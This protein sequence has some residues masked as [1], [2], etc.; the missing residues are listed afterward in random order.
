MAPGHDTSIAGGR[1]WA[2]AAAMHMR[3][4]ATRGTTV[5]NMPMAIVRSPRN[6]GFALP[7]IL[8]LSLVLLTMLLAAIAAMTTIRQ[9]L[10]SA[11]YDRAAK[12]AAEAG[13][14]YAASCMTKNGFVSTWTDASPLVPG[15]D[16]NGGAQCAPNPDCAVVRTPQY[17]ST[18]SVGAPV[19][20]GTGSQFITARGEVSLQ[21]SSSAT[22]SWKTYTYNLQARIG[23]SILV[24]N[25]AF[26]YSSAGTNFFTLGRDGNV[27]AVGANGAGQL[28]TGSTANA[29]LPTIVNMPS[30]AQ[31]SMTNPNPITT[32][33]LNSGFAAGIAASNGNAYFSGPNNYYQQGMTGSSPNTFVA[34]PLPGLSNE[35]K[36]LGP[37]VAAIPVFYNNYVITANGYVFA[38]GNCEQ[39]QTGTYMIGD[40][41][42]VA[43][44]R[45]ITALPAPRSGDPS[46]LPKTITGDDQVR[47]ILMKDG[48][49]YGWGRDNDSPGW[50]TGSIGIGNGINNGVSYPRPIMLEGQLNCT[51]TGSSLCPMGAR[52]KECK[53][54]DLSTIHCVVNVEETGRATYLLANDGTVWSAGSDWGRGLLGLGSKDARTS[55]FKQITQFPNDGYSHKVVSIHAD[56]FSLSMLTE[57][58]G[59]PWMSAVYTVGYNA[60]GLAGCGVPSGVGG[61]EIGCPEIATRPV[62]F[63]LPSGVYPIYMYNTSNVTTVGG[64]FIAQTDNLYVIGSDKKAYAAGDDTFGQLGDQ[65]VLQGP[66]PYSSCQYASNGQ[67]ANQVGTPVVMSILDGSDKSRTALSI[68]AG[69]GTAVIKAESGIV[70]AV[71]LNDGGQLGDGTTNNSSVPRPNKY[72]NATATLYY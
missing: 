49:V 70:Y 29:L 24:N 30:G 11:Q 61:D 62:R 57:E 13:I 65:C 37:V 35:G 51:T 48:S 18:F 4:F 9:A 67:P 39:G 63:K 36:P 3:R 7:T 15:R 5:Y 26:G 44:P 6:R 55:T 43:T 27:R 2:Q 33:F 54:G 72:L 47:H 41:C 38:S 46:T 23:G 34:Y 20:N 52:Q 32:N 19:G 17:H 1:G 66:A 42:K 50:M 28:G 64:F 53:L 21:R 60:T 58:P 25:V 69:R 71:G 40:G 22:K 16:C 68:Q 10:F 31:A 59:K 56:A 14:N 8:I 45:Q 12:L